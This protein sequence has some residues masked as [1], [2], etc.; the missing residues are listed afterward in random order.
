MHE[1]ALAESVIKTIKNDKSLYKLSQIEII[2]GEL[3]SIDREIFLFAF[4][5]ITRKEKKIPKIKIIEEKAEFKCL[6]CG[7]IFNLSSIKNNDD[8]KEN[9]HFI[10]EMAKAFIK[11]PK[12][13]SSDFEIIKGRGISIRINKH[14]PTP[15]VD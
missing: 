13:K 9:I 10:P 3:Q 12:C 2:F 8:E 6:N 11:C 5:E 1:W 4:N 14:L 15:G 7:R